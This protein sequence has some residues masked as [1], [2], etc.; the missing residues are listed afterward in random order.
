MLITP[1][2]FLGGILLFENRQFDFG[3]RAIWVFGLSRSICH[4][5]DQTLRTCESN[6]CKPN[7]RILPLLGKIRLTDDRI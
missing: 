5:S 1:L 7:M 4:L 2:P 3:E 6:N